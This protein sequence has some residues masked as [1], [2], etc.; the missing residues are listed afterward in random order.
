MK[1]KFQSE[2]KLQSGKIKL[3]KNALE[4][5][6]I[7]K[8]WRKDPKYKTEL[9]K[10]FEA[11]GICVYGNKCRFA[12]G[13][14]ELFG[15]SLSTTNYKQ[16]ECFSFYT[17]GF[18]AY[19]KRCHF[20]H[21]DVHLFDL[22]RSYYQYL[23][24]ILPKG[25]ENEFIVSGKG[26]EP[27]SVLTSPV[28]KAGK[29]NSSSSSSIN[30]SSVSTLSCESSKVLPFPLV[31]PFSE[32]LEEGSRLRIFNEI[33]LNSVKKNLCESFSHCDNTGYMM[34]CNYSTIVSLI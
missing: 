14:Q 15:K 11:K 27:T 32:P 21:S 20:I 5:V 30:K 18:C 17:Q 7:E 4:E 12:H 24:E 1:G 8:E 25:S 10:S 9:C 19:G 29:T 13:K 22:K 2:S 16:K 34:N 6:D 33:H 3:K 28:L 23:L 31:S 26:N